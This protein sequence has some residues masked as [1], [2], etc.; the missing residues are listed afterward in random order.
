M[1]EERDKEEGMKVKDWYE[2]HLV[3]NY[4]CIGKGWVPIVKR[5]CEDI[6][7]ADPE[8]EVSQVKEKFGGLRFYT[9]GTTDE[10]FDLIENAE[11]KSFETCEV[12]G[13]PGTLREG[14]WVLTL[15]DECAKKDGRKV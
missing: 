5:L 4:W 8:C 15:C 7:K 10:V 3:D 2:K 9:G 13:E 11:I 14:G 6:I 12:C 1:D